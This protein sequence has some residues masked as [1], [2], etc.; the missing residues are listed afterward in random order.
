MEGEKL[1]SLSGSLM[2]INEDITMTFKDKKH[3][4]F[5]LSCSFNHGT[6]I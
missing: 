4:S 5:N 2:N 6:F 3:Y 1:S